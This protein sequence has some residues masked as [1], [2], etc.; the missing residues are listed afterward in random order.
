MRINGEAIV[1]P[2]LA[3]PRGGE[4]SRPANAVNDVIERAAA[5][6]AHAHMKNRNVGRHTAHSDVVLRG[7]NRS[8][9]MRAMP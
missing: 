2:L 5:G 3:I 6:V 1:A 8:G 7:A 4:A 9:D